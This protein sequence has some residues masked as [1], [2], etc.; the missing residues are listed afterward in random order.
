[1]WRSIQG[2]TKMRQ[3]ICDRC[4]VVIPRYNKYHHVIFY[5][6]DVTFS[7]VQFNNTYNECDLCDDCLEYLH[8]MNQAF[9][10]NYELFVK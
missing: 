6:K 8:N 3:Y 5:D 9:M 2:G 7:D 1:M 10:E 4:G